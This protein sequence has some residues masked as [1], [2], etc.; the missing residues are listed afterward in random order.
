[1]CVYIWL[2]LIGILF[3]GFVWCS[4]SNRYIVACCLLLVNCRHF[5]ICTWWWHNEIL[6]MGV[7]PHGVMVIIKLCAS[8]D[9]RP[10]LIVI[11]RPVDC[12]WIFILWCFDLKLPSFALRLQF[13]ADLSLPRHGITSLES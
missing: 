6:Y 13:A 2:C 1:M 10:L 11:F 4:L 7:R 5:V 8:S 3:K 12:V 9:A